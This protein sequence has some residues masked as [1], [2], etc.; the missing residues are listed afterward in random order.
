MASVTLGSIDECYT[1]QQEGKG[2]RHSKDGEGHFGVGEGGTGHF[3]PGDGKADLHCFLTPA[4]GPLALYM[5]LLG[6][7]PDLT[8]STEQ[9]RMIHRLSQRSLNSAHGPN[10]VFGD[11]VS[12]CEPCLPWKCWTIFQRNCSSRSVLEG[13][14]AGCQAWTQLA[15]TSLPANQL[16]NGA[17]LPWNGKHC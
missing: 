11:T 8:I 14:A 7:A 2:R 5:E 3:V 13:C 1:R 17:V 15:R 16:A 4:Q 10:L 6:S 12:L 9:A